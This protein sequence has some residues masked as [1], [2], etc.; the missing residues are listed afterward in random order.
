[1]VT[2]PLRVLPGFAAMVR[3]TLPLPVPLVPDLIVMNVALLTAVHAQVV[4]FAPTVTVI[5]SPPPFA[6]ALVDPTANAHVGVVVV[7]VVVDV[8]EEGVVELLE[9]APA[10]IAA[11]NP[12]LAATADNGTSRLRM[13]RI[14]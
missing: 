7:V 13:G 9:Q 14:F 4:A 8:V 2:V 6:L 12:I 1:M 3:T 11:T 10:N 5:V